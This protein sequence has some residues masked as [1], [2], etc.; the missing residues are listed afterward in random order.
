MALAVV[1]HLLNSKQE[2]LGI[3]RIVK[4]FGDKTADK[5]I[6]YLFDDFT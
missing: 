4:E 6:K 5:I 3:E 2:T 1:I